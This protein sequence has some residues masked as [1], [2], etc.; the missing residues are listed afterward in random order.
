VILSFSRDV[1]MQRIISGQKKHTIRED[2]QRRWRVGM[3]AQL[4]M[5]SPRN[6]SKNPFQ[7]GEAVITAIVD[8]KISRAQRK[9]F[10]R[11]T[12]KPHWYDID[13]ERLARDDG[14]DSVDG[15]LEWLSGDFEGRLLTWGQ[16]RCLGHIIVDELGEYNGETYQKLRSKVSL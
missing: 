9:A 14:F 7:F 1:F 2:Q 13:I 11:Y 4:W 3:H 15:L 6:V 12:G 5:H 10:F 8:V 16:F